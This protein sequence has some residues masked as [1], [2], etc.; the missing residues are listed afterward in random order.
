MLSS[1]PGRVLRKTRHYLGRV[2]GAE[3]S[4]DVF[5]DALSGL[6]EAGFHEQD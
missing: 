3:L 6:V 1:L 2:D 4:V 5:E